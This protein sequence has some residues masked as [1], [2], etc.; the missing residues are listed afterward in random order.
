MSTQGR[1]PRRLSEGGR[2]LAVTAH[3]G[4]SALSPPQL[5]LRLPSALAASLL[6]T[7]QENS[8]TSWDSPLDSL[9]REPMNSIQENSKAQEISPLHS[10]PSLNL[11]HILVTRKCPPA[12]TAH[13]C[14]PTGRTSCRPAHQHVCFLDQEQA[15][16]LRTIGFLSLGAASCSFPRSPHTPLHTSFPVRTHGSGRPG[17]CS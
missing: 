15:Q 3:V 17:L 4:R 16:V 10:A 11:L 2:G 9:L 7:L 14:L 12:G 13:A 8:Y 5:L 6:T 1:G